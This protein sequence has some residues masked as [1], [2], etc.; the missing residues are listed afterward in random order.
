MGGVLCDEALK[1]VSLYGE[2]PSAQWYY[3]PGGADWERL[4][5]IVMAASALNLQLSAGGSQR[6]GYPCS[7]FV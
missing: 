3:I 1:V 7:R 4:D 6:Y 2:E 5:E